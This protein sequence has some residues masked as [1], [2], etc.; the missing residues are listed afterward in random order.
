MGAQIRKPRE[1]CL[2]RE[3]IGS[4]GWGYVGQD[5][6][7]LGRRAN[8]RVGRKGAGIEVGG[9]LLPPHA[10]SYPQWSPAAGG[11]GRW[12]GRGYGRRG[13]GR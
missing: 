1:Q 8:V 7:L 9:K 10:T 2:P 12:E 11:G 13:R 4:T 5:V 6:N 3:E